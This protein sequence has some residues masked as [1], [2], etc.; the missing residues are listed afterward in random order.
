MFSRP[1]AATSWYSAGR[2]QLRSFSRKMAACTVVTSWRLT[3][4]SPPLASSSAR[5]KESPKAVSTL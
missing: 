3:V 1:V 4:D 2:A 5:S